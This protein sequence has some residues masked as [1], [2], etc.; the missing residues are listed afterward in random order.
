MKIRHKF[1]RFAPIGIVVS[2]IFALSVLPAAAVDIYYGNFF[3]APISSIRHHST[4]S[5]VAIDGVPNL[6]EISTTVTSDSG[7]T[8]FP[9]E[10]YFDYPWFTSSN[11]TLELSFICS[12]PSAV[13]SA[14]FMIGGK[15]FTLSRSTD[16]GVT[17]CTA[18]LSGMLFSDHPCIG[19]NI[20]TY[21]DA[22]SVYLQLLGCTVKYNMS[23]SEYAPDANFIGGRSGLS[24]SLNAD[25]FNIPS[26]ELFVAGTPGQEVRT[27][28]TSAYSYGIKAPAS[29]DQIQYIMLEGSI[30]LYLQGS[31]EYVTC[32]IDSPGELCYLVAVDADGKPLYTNTYSFVSDCTSTELV[33][34]YVVTSYQ[35]KGRE[36][37]IIGGTTS[38][39]ATSADDSPKVGM[40][41]QQ[42][43]TS[44][45][46]YYTDATEFEYAEK[47]QYYYS[48]ENWTVEQFGSILTRS[49]SSF[50][51]TVDEMP[52][53]TLHVAF[54][55]P[56]TSDPEDIV[57]NFSC[58]SSSAISPSLVS[59]DAQYIASVFGSETSRIVSA[60][61]EFF[62]DAT[63]LNEA[64]EV[65]ENAF[66]SSN[67]LNQDAFASMGDVCSNYNDYRT[68]LD[69]FITSDGNA[70]VNGFQV[71]KTALQ[72]F[73]D[74]YTAGNMLWVFG[75]IAFFGVAAYIVSRGRVPRSSSKE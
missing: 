73:I 41:T 42:S 23:A 18:R 50:S 17:V 21:D 54:L 40:I 9:I 68:K 36:N 28:Y 43:G 34:D 56:C 13:K 37:M 4:E 74:A 59:V 66:N 35:I 45:Y 60:I 29:D 10:F 1:L 61:R 55:L 52:S 71:L 8:F 32:S 53:V 12:N 25:L 57:L 58:V 22:S 38:N 7:T 15:S 11:L 26:S 3:D 62:P 20:K 65:A 48:T 16:N 24:Y 39:I 51:F 64:I 67:Q 46:Y 47:D 44:Y 5:V 6:Y 49:T 2:L 69:A 33:T 31:L 14:Y 72:T 70:F 19:F 27:P 75:R 63:A 30:E